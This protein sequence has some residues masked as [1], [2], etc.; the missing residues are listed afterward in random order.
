MT[1]N[2]VEVGHVLVSHTGEILRADAGFC[3]IM[4]A[5]PASLTGRALISV[6]APE[7]RVVCADLIKTLRQTRQPFRV[8][9]R[10]LRDDGSTVWVDKTV[11]IADFGDDTE[12][13][14][15]LIMATVVPIVDPGR[16]EDPARLLGM[17][18]FLRE[19]RRAQAM[20]FAA[21]G[22]GDIAWAF[23]LAAYIAEA[24][25]QALSE[26]EISRELRLARAV[27][28]RWIRALEA[29]ELIEAEHDGEHFRLSATAHARFEAYLAN[30]ILKAPVSR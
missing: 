26:A 6:T 12:A 21:V 29:D 10:L 3:A 19:S 7:D 28:L 1:T 16:L 14:P 30:R 24:S 23:L 11:A 22:S 8:A 9:K 5:T 15:T 13:S 25:G 18:L 17:A 27:T 20:M 2:T 4:R